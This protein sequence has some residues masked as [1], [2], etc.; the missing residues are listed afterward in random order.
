MLN[1]RD[2]ELRFRGDY[3]IAYRS[4]LTR[5]LAPTGLLFKLLNLNFCNFASISNFEKL[6][7]TAFDHVSPSKGVAGLSLQLGEQDAGRGTDSMLVPD[8]QFSETQTQMQA[9]QTQ[10]TQPQSQ[11]FPHGVW[12]ILVSC[13]PQ[14]TLEAA[15]FVERP[16]RVELVVGKDAY[17][18]GRDPRCDIVLAG[19]K[20]SAKQAR[21]YIVEGEEDGGTAGTEVR[22]EDTGTN[23]TYVRGKKVGRGNTTILYHGDEVVFGPATSSL[24][25]DFRYVFQSP[26]AVKVPLYTTK[27][28]SG[29]DEFYEMRESI[30]KGSF[31]T[32]YEAIQKSTGRSVAIK[33]IKKARF[34]D[35]KTMLMLR[36]EI[37]IMKVLDHVRP[38]SPSPLTVVEMFENRSTAFSI[39]I[40]SRTT[41]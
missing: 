29:I 40:S 34:K 31:A 15:N 6:A 26:F 18:I 17:S 2:R 23:G 5:S 12:G 7:L 16:A 27:S 36:R 35:Q 19:K 3:Q 32:V 13:A 11:Q 38:S 21:I 22:L 20:I 25:S 9:T 28:S 24:L 8:S 37:E 1:T 14:S 4:R 39:W 41:N 33:V 10:A 30:G